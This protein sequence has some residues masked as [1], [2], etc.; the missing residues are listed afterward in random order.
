MKV[1]GGI[2]PRSGRGCQGPA[3]CGHSRV[4]SDEGDRV[5][6]VLPISHTPP[7][8]P[9]LAVELPAATK[10]RL[11]LD[12]ERSWVVLTKANRFPAQALLAPDPT[13][14]ATLRRKGAG[15]GPAAGSPRG[16][17]KRYPW[18]A[19]VRAIRNHPAAIHRRDPG[20]PRPSRAAQH[21]T[22]AGGGRKSARTRMTGHP[23]VISTSCV[24]KR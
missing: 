22:D 18:I 21:M 5:V 23:R 4:G 10:R 17:C 12:D 11:G 7:A 13:G 2:R 6:T 3:L 19:A 1:T 8:D 14:E 24:R 20:A 15:S 9:E 16:R